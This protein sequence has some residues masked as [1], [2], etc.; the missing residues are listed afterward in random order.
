MW[1]PLFSRFR[2]VL[3]AAIPDPNA[4]PWLP[5]SSDARQASRAP[6]VGFCERVYSYPLCTPG[7]S[8]AYVDVW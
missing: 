4:R 3:V 2:T 6:R 5:P 7:D 1:S 8:W